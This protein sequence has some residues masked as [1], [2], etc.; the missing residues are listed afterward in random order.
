VLVRSVLVPAL[1]VL[2]GRVGTWPA[3][4]GVRGYRD[5]GRADIVM[6]SRL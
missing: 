1:V 5:V 4:R 2:F 3:H 6:K